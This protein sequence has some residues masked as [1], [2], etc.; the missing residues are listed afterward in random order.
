MFKHF[1]FLIGTYLTGYIMNCPLLLF[2]ISTGAET[3]FLIAQNIYFFKVNL[4]LFLLYLRVVYKK[5]SH[6]YIYFSIT[7]LDYFWTVLVLTLVFSIALHFELKFSPSF[8]VKPYCGNKDTRYIRHG[9]RW[10]K[11]KLLSQCL[12]HKSIYLI[13]LLWRWTQFL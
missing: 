1:I 12:P 11:N 9:L 2:L 3:F 13:W 5:F 8:L 10:S 4:E 6:K 7:W